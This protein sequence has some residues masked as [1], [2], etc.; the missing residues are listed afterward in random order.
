MLAGES[1]DYWY[2]KTQTY[3]LKG[4]RIEPPEHLPEIASALLERGYQPEDVR[5]IMGGT[6]LRVAEATWPARKRSI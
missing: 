1:R 6:I 3:D 4:M 5:R 2:L